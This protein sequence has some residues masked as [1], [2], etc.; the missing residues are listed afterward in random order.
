MKR[1][2]RKF[3]MLFW[4]SGGIVLSF[5]VIALFAPYIANSPT[6]FRYALI[7]F[8]PESGDILT[9]K[10]LAAPDSVHWFGTDYI[11]NDILARLIYG[12]RNSLFFSCAVVTIC[13]SLGVTLGGIMGFFGGW[14]DLTM[15]RLME[16]IG[17]FPIFLLQLTLLAFL[18]QGY[19]VLLFV[20]CLAGWIPYCRFARAE[21]LRLRNQDF[22]QAAEVIGASKP[23]IFFKH[24]LPNSLTPI[25]TFI[26]FDLTST[27]I[28]L[29]ALS[30][31]GFG[32]PI[33]VASIGELLKQ[34]KDH[35]T[36]AWWLAVFPGTCLFLLTFSLAVFGS[37]IRDLLDPRAK[38]K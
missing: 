9:S 31:L 17:N 19:G 29:G 22:V 10:I 27:I 18:S 15:S 38:L 6:E 7:P 37:E 25:I 11:G 14:I 16:V 13:M 33:N 5:F 1:F 21:F 24:L 34:A 23:R 8:G 2:L 26:P 4:V 20:M 36:Q 32:E 12:I 35:F 3:S 28:S 30:F